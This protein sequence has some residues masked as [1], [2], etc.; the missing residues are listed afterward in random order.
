MFQLGKQENKTVFQ[1]VKKN[2]NNNNKKEQVNKMQMIIF[3]HL[4]QIYKGK[5]IFNN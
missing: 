2:K 4:H 3:Y 1:S 5:N